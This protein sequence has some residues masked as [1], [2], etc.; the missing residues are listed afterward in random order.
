MQTRLHL[1]SIISILL[2]VVLLLNGVAVFAAPPADSPD[3]PT[4]VLAVLPASQNLDTALRTARSA[5]IQVR[6]VF[7]PDAFIAKVS[8][9]SPADFPGAQT[10]TAP[11]DP[12]VATQWTPSARQ[13]AA[14]FNAL[15]APPIT[16]KTAQSLDAHPLQP[17]D[18]VDAMEAPAP[19]TPRFSPENITA[20]DLRPNYTESSQF[21][22]GSV[23]VGI[24]FPESSGATDPST[25]DWTDSEKS[26]VVSEIASAL[27]W[28]AEREPAAQLSVVYDAPHTESTAVEP[29]SRPYTDQSLW[30]AD[31]MTAMGFSGYSYFDQVRAYNDHLRQTYRTDWAF[32]IFVAD[33]SNDS[34]NRFSDGYFAYAYLGGPFMVMTSGNNGYGIGNMDAVATHEMGHI[35]RALDQYSSANVACT[36]Q[37]GYLQIENQNSQQGC[38]IN[39]PSIM[40]GQLSPY[41]N[42]QIDMYARGQIGWQD[43]DGNGI[44]D[45]VDVGLTVSGVSTATVAATGVFTVSGHFT[46]TPFPSPKYRAILINSVETVNYRVDSGVWQP[47]QPVDGAFDNYQDDF[48]FTTDPLPNGAHTLY[49]QTVDN[50]GKVNDRTISTVTVSGVTEAIDT[51]FTTASDRLTVQATSAAPIAGTAMQLANGTIVGVEYRLDGGGWQS[52]DP[53]DGAFGSASESFSILLDTIALSAGDH[54]LEAR[55]TDNFGA[56]DTTPARMT[57]SVQASP[58]PFNIFLPLVV[59]R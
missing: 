17:G 59:T 7:P 43:G 23:A 18:F 56:V 8:G 22:M 2:T 12:A 31:T 41:A 5:G 44:L 6:H 30:V 1:P 33:S 10:F 47:A 20:A 28:W 15:L 53:A 13:A 32:T 52:A 9:G 49:L 39:E 34:D 38:A 46:E 55:A 58:Q 48:T 19:E 26:Q 40:R 3:T 4:L 42:R 35:F 50:F 14:V 11:V 24:V 45:P 25:E 57:V 51:Q 27:D 29:I 36:V 21:M 54:L 16:E 37:S